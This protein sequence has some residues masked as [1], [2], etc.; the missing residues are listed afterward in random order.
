[1]TRFLQRWGVFAGLVVVW[2]L[3]TWL[4]DDTFFPRPTAIAEAARA[5]WLSGPADR[6]FLT[7]TVFEHVFP[8]VGRLLAGW[9]IAALIG[10]SLGVALGRSA[11]AMQFAGPLL[12]FLRSIPPPALV[13]VFL[14]VFNIGTQMQ[15][16]TIVFGV[17]WPILLNSVDG[18]RSVDATKYETSAVFR[19][20][21]PQWVLGVVLPAAAPKIF[22][23]LRVSLSL[24][25]VL[26]VVSELVGTDNGIGSQLLVAQREFDFPDMWAGIVLLGVLGYAL[27]TVL[28]AFERRALAWQPKQERT[29]ATVE[30]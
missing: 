15:L 10:V 4:A 20:P 22:A 13:P 9:G 27:N 23:G 5:L 30:D 18:A 28:L 7:D 12:T 16:A 11:T 14:L 2:E 21:K 25:L 8:S 19:I 24:S 3:L 29:P 1:M 6:L 26:M 17:L